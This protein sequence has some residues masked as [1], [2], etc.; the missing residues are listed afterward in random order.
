MPFQQKK[1]IPHPSVVSLPVK[2]QLSAKYISDF[3][4]DTI[5]KVHL[6]TVIRKVCKVDRFIK[7]EKIPVYES[8]SPCMNHNKE[9]QKGKKERKKRK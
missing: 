1:L 4:A 5:G 7:V 8:R 9:K 3:S 6:K 2:C